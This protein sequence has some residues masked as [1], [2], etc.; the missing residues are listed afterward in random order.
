LPTQ[1]FNLTNLSGSQSKPDIAILN[2][3]FHIVYSELTG[4]E[5]KYIRVNAVNALPENELLADLFVYPNPAKNTVQVD[6]SGLT[7]S[8]GLICITDLTGRVLS[9]QQLVMGASTVSVD[10]TALAAGTYILQLVADGQL[11]TVSF[12]KN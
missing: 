9:T 12:V 3:A 2:G 4:A 6:L 8:S 11:R 5:V 7:F 1:A 10:L